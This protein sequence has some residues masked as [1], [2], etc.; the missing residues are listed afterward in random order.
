MNTSLRENTCCFSGYR[1]G[2]LP[3]GYNETAPDCLKLKLLIA[4]AVRTAYDAGFRHF[5]CGM[6]TGAD[7]YFGEAVVALRDECPDVTLEAAIPYQGQEERWPKAQRLRY[8]RLAEACDAVTVLHEAHIPG[9]MMERNRYM[10]DR[11]S[12]VIAIYDDRRRGGT[13]NTLKY[14][15]AVGCPAVILPVTGASPGRP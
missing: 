9:C 6:S 10:V 2:K 1:A 11:S 7:T 8:S 13:Y 15:E 4:D 3:W 5:I 12:L 14:A